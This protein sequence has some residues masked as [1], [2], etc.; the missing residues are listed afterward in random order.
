MLPW[1][2]MAPLATPV[3]PPV[4]CRKARSSRRERRLVER[5]RAAR[6]E[7][8]IEADRAVQPPARHH[9]LHVLDHRVRQHALERRQQ[10]ADLRRDH[11]AH[12]AWP[13][14]P[15]RAC[16][17]SSPAPRWP[18]RRLSLQLVLEFARRVERVD[19]DHHHAGPQGAEH[20][21]P[22]T[23]AGWA[24]SARRGRRASVRRPSAARR[25]RRG[26][27]RRAAGSVITVPIELKAGRSAKR[28][29]L[30]SSTSLSEASGPKS[31]SAGTAAGYWASQGLFMRILANRWGVV[32]PAR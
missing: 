23:A 18:R 4:Y 19:V 13:G 29:Q 9:L 1:V 22:G 6:G 10:V 2:S 26:S 20:A 5:L 30:A 17:R 15:A 8:A 21:P 28:A 7:H 11:D 3:V 27:P 31:I 12:A 32:L 16:A 24:S 25:R 14:S